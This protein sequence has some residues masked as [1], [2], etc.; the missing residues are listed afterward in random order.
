MDPEIARLLAPPPGGFA[1][2]VG[3]A[4]DL[5]PYVRVK[6]KG[7]V[8]FNMPK[9]LTK[10]EEKAVRRKLIAYINTAP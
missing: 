3:G 4:R 1:V 2:G 5:R 7:D 6:G 10:V 8:H 9:G